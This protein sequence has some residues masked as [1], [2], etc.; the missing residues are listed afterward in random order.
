MLGD[1]PSAGTACGIGRRF[2]AAQLRGWQVDE[3][4]VE[5]AVLITSEL[6]AN[7]VNHAPPP[8]HLQVSLDGRR[9]RIEVT[10]ASPLPPEIVSPGAL[11][12]GGRGL[13]LIGRLASGWG[14]EPQAPGKVVWCEVILPA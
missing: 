8:G 9:V 14:W 6:V 12:T 5:V 2:V 11:A 10:D 4:I 13:L 7:A 1:L 3:S